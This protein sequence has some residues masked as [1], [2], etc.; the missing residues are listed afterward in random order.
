MKI[1]RHLLSYFRI[2]YF[3]T[4]KMIIPVVTWIIFLIS[5]YS[6]IGQ[7]WIESVVFSSIFLF[8]ISAW[9]AYVYMDG[10][11]IIDEQLLM[12]KV[13]NFNV[14][15]NSKIIFVYL[16]GFCLGLMG[17]VLPIMLNYIR[18]FALFGEIIDIK[19]I[20]GALIFYFIISILAGTLGMFFQPRYFKNRKISVTLTV[21]ITIMTIVKSSIIRKYKLSKYILWILPPFSNIIQ[22]FDSKHIFN[23]LGLGIALCY[24]FI[25]SFIMLMVSRYLL[26]KTLF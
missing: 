8:V 6:N 17:I 20:F 24:S 14:Y 10:I 16:I 2:N 4:N 7:T 1:Y 13:K 26:K 12:L 22:C 3:K 21:L 19:S 25:Y 5:Y 15:Y 23:F 11:N 9:I 18:K